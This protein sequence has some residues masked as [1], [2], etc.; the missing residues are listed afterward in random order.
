MKKLLVLATLMAPAIASADGYV[1]GAGRWTCAEVVRVGDSGSP[2]EVG[3]VAGWVFGF[4][5]AAT[6]E[7][8]TSFVDVVENVGGDAI[9]D[10]TIAEC[11][12]APEGT[13]L[14]PIVQSMIRN[15]K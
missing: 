10:A 8:E 5:T 4:W 11:R 14:Y 2:I 9:L 3:Q 6:F 1:I 7:R 13:L 12:D 15:T